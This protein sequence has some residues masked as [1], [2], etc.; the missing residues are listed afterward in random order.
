MGGHMGGCIQE[1]FSGPPCGPGRMFN[2]VRNH[3]QKQL[4]NTCPFLTEIASVGKLHWEWFIS[5]TESLM[6]NV[7][8]LLCPSLYS[9]MYAC[10]CA[11]I[12]VYVDLRMSTNMCMLT[13]GAYKGIPRSFIHLRFLVKDD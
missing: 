10:L 12:Y 5:L 11:D 13:C 2:G 6:C 3:R 9:Y 8:F 7:A 4:V 1:W